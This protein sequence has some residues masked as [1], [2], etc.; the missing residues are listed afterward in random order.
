MPT[1]Q[2]ASSAGA[3]QQARSERRRASR[4]ARDAA[5]A[6]DACAGRSRGAESA[7]VRPPP[8]LLPRRSES[9]R[10]DD[11]FCGRRR[12]RHPLD[13]DRLVA[14]RRDQV[15]LLG[16]ERSIRCGDRSVSISRRSCRLIS[17]CSARSL[18]HLLD[19]VA[20]P[21]QLEV[22]PG[23]EQQHERPGTPPI[24]DRSATARAAAPRRPRG[25]SGCCGRPS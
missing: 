19:L 11:G 22:L 4:T 3:D 6:A 14:R 8:I 16:R 9:A 17:S 15:Q 5:R 13:D 20:V 7:R 25:R 21:Q 18:L 1:V 2:H 12:R 23:R 10:R 24:A